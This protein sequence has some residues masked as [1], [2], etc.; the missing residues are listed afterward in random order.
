M[1]G[2]LL[3]TD[4]AW[5]DLRVETAVLGEAG[6]EM[7]LADTGE[8]AEVTRLA[9]DVDAILTC[10]AK[11]PAG[12]IDAAIRCQTVARYGVGVDNIDLQRA[13]ELGILALARRLLPLAR[14]DGK[15]PV[16]YLTEDERHTTRGLARRLLGQPPAS[17]L[18]AWEMLQ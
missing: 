15:S 3:V 4:D 17:I 14:V 13:A 10:F 5:P 18:D 2:R 6:I 9:A 12:V 1:T 16:E 7:V 8:T 11:V